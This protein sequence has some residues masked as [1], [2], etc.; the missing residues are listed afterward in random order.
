MC[1]HFFLFH[2]SRARTSNAW[3]VVGGNI[4]KVGETSPVSDPDGVVD[5]V[6]VCMSFACQDRQ[7]SLSRL[8]VF[9][10]LFRE[11][12]VFAWRNVINS[13]ISRAWY[14]TERSHASFGSDAGKCVYSWIPCGRSFRHV[15]SHGR[16][17]FVA[18]SF[19]RE[20]CCIRAT[21]RALNTRERAYTPGVSLQDMERAHSTSNW[22]I[23]TIGRIIICL[24]MC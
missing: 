23:S 16:G 22:W 12:R 21:G 15:A 11:F 5:L 3:Q 13:H 9:I 14:S 7:L 18:S 6:K 19:P 24:S 4:K 17:W 10:Y 20:S 2:F 1:F 8:C